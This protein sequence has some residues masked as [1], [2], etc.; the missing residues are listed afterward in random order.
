MKDDDV[1][2]RL[3]AYADRWAAT[4]PSPPPVDLRRARRIRGVQMLSLAAAVLV[5]VAAATLVPTLLRPDPGQPARSG[6]DR[7]ADTSSAEPSPVSPTLELTPVPPPPRRCRPVEVRPSYL[8][9]LEEGEPIPDPNISHFPGRRPWVYSSWTD[10]ASSS[11]RNRHRVVLARYSGSSGTGDEV[12]VRLQ[13][14]L[15]QYYDD[16]V[17]T[18]GSILWRMPGGH[19]NIVALGLEA[20]ATDEDWAHQRKA[21]LDARRM[22]IRIAESL[23]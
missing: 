18:G 14:V 2:R 5:I 3:R 4:Q 23:K 17:P 19:C 9:W 16:K 13:G 10:P 1:D 6:P 20:P 12:D 7:A 22:V 15:G 8:P 21:R 11:L